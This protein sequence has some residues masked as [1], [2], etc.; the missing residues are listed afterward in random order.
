MISV[1][2]LPRVAPGKHYRPEVVAVIPARN[3]QE[4]IADT[5]HSVQQQTRQPDRIVVVINNTTDDTATAAEAAGA[6]AVT[7]PGHNPHMKSGALNYALDPLLEELRDEDFVLV[8]DADTTLDPC[9]IDIS[10]EQ[11][12][13]DK[14]IGGVSSIFRGRPTTSLLGYLQSMEYFR[15]GRQLKRFANQAFVLSGTASLIRVDALR[16]I[17]EERRRGVLLPEREGV[18]DI[19]TITEDNELTLA[20]KTLGYDCMAPGVVSTTDVMEKLGALRKQRVRWY[21][22]AI[23]N[24]QAYG[25]KLPWH[26]RWTYWRQQFGLLLSV[27]VIVLMLAALGI[28]ITGYI[29]GFVGFSWP[30]FLLIGVLPTVVHL[31]ERVSSVWGMGKRA[32]LIA[33]AYFPEVLYS[34]ILVAIYA[35]ALSEVVRGKKGAWHQT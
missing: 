10:L 20:L 35:I 21:R 1:L 6:H 31:I 5:V 3:E 26:L 32:R 17:K 16:R 7:M 15:Y 2:E 22:G 14:F 29:G 11:F 8:M 9:F 25:R 12:A 23:E 30:M 27:F 4:T 24:L 13:T 33:L 34:M 28:T 19:D 18:Y